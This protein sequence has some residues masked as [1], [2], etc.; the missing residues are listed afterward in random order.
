MMGIRFTEEQMAEIQKRWEKRE[1]MSKTPAAVM[2]QAPKVSP[3]KTPKSAPKNRLEDKMIALIKEA[4]LPLP[5]AQ[6]QHI[7]DREYRLDFAYPELCIGIEC[8]GQ[9]HRIRE[10][11][12]ADI[13]KRALGQINGWLVLEVD[14]PA[15]E[16]G[17]AVAWLKT[18]M[19]KRWNR[20]AP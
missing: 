17:M 3:K 18:L 2:V 13:E 4:G 1:P 15:I 5:W 12:H 7:P 19:M 10:K 9:V 8:Q 16:S 6:Y 14:G 20:E 11:H